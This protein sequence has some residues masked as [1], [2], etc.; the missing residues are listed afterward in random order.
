MMMRSE[1]NATLVTGP[2]KFS[3][4]EKVAPDAEVVR[5][6]ERVR[7]PRVAE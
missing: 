4:Q 7:S 6:D 5:P 2:H 1:W 3:G